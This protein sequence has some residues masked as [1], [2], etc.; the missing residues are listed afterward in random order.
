MS[1]GAD[2]VCAV[3]ARASRGRA[4]QLAWAYLSRVVEGPSGPLAA[5]VAAVG[6]EDAA[7]AVRERS[8]P[9]A[10]EVAT[11]ARREV[12]CAAHDLRAVAGVGGR[13]VTP[14][15]AEWPGWRMH[16]FA[17]SGGGAAVHGVDPVGAP[18]IALWVRGA[19]R[20]DGLLHRALAV[21]GTRAATAYGEQATAE[22]AGDLAAGGWTVVSGGAYGIDGCAHRAALAVGAPTVAVLACGVDRA[23]PAGHARLLE[24]VA[25]TGLVVSEYPP[26][27][28]PMRFRFL[29]RNRLVA[30][31]T[32]GTLVVEAGL[33]SGAR[34]TVRWA[35]QFGKPT[36]AV[37]GPIFSAAS[38]GCHLMVTTGEARLVVGADAVE[39]VVGP[40]GSLPL[41]PD[42][43]AADGSDAL[44]GARKRVYEALPASGSSSAPEVSVA[45]GLP[46][47]VV[48]VAL[49][50]LA[51][52][53]FAA[54]DESGW[55]RS[56]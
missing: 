53:G 38:V 47:E 8:L 15:D 25:R 56:R 17:V 55:F 30:G 33:R 41:A 5:L 9:E 21:V 32:D 37:P 7:R 40:V 4:R 35:R 49:V 1:A 45:A 3:A 39:E 36:L 54:P 52:A 22:I 28:A 42:T 44:R 34:N 48:E 26:G 31:L 10:L 16:V 20:L 12:D 46:V 24:Q 27:T 18:P 19:A 43:A 51:A 50:E 23:Y 2:D 14:D 11:R 6:P 29:A 13:L